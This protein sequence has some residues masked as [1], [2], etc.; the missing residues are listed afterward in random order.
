MQGLSSLLSLEQLARSPE[1]DRVLEEQTPPKVRQESQF[2]NH[3]PVVNNNAYYTRGLYFAIVGAPQ[4][5]FLDRVHLFS[6]LTSSWNSQVLD[7]GRLELRSH[8]RSDILPRARVAS[9]ANT[10]PDPYTPAHIIC[11]AA[12]HFLSRETFTELTFKLSHTVPFNITNKQY[13]VA[14]RNSRG[15]VPGRSSVPGERAELWL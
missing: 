3:L 2:T 14:A 10:F 9:T 8:Q 15:L 1:A 12:L 13:A 7:R 11:F 4:V 6:F 5:T